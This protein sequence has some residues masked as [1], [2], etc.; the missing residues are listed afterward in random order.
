MTPNCEILDRYIQL[1]ILGCSIVLGLV[2]LYI[3]PFSLQIISE[4][5]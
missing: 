4:T 2:H 1:Q 3:I 5:A